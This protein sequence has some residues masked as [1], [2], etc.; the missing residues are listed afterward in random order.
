METYFKNKVI[1]LNVIF[2]FLIVFAHSKLPERY[3]LTTDWQYPLCYIIGVL[4]RTATPSFFFMSALLFY[5]RCSAS[6]IKRKLTSRIH[7]LLIPYLLWNTLFVLIYFTIT[8]IPFAVSNM[9]MG[10][11]AFNGFPSIVYAILNS[12]HT[13]LWFVK[14]LIIFSILS[15]VILFIL[16][17]KV[18]LTIIFLLSICIVCVYEP[19]HR[20]LFRWIPIYIMGAFC[21]FYWENPRI[22]R[23]LNSPQSGHITLIISLIF[24][25][26]YIAT[27]LANNDLYIFRF[28]SPLLLWILTDGIASNY[29]KDRFVCKKWMR[30]MFFIYC[31][32]HF[33]LNILQKVVVLNFE[34]SSIVINITFM[35]TPII[36]IM[37][38]LTIAH[39]ISHTSLYK[40]LCGS[41]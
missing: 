38:L 16:K 29:I 10:E 6:D 5:K 41:R 23:T 13:D 21:G 15:P 39:K 17:R 4:C 3:G 28:C 32:H 9:N 19:A 22:Q 7:T 12:T 36:T 40:I 18:L 2:T 24:L 33:V 37:I 1:I 31:T 26:L 11:N 14:N 30:Y 34:P 8:H 27:L 20:S 25:T 35:I